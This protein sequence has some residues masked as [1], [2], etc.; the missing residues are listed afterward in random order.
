MLRLFYDYIDVTQSNNYV[1]NFLL[2]CLFKNFS[3]FSSIDVTQF[4]LRRGRICA[5]LVEQFGAGLGD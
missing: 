2:F 1:F 4:I 5:L 3:H